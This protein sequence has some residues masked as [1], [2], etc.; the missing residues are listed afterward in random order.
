METTT[1]NYFHGSRE[2]TL[3]YWSSKWGNEWEPHQIIL[4]T[5]LVFVA[6][7]G[8]SSENFHPF[9][10]ISDTNNSYAYAIPWSG[11]W[12]V[13]IARI[14]GSVQ[15]SLESENPNLVGI[16]A[17]VVSGLWEDATNQLLKDFR[18]KHFATRKL[19]M[20]TE[21]NHWWPYEGTLINEDV[22]LRNAQV[23]QQCGIEVA[24]LDSGWFGSGA[25]ED[26]RGDWNQVNLTRFPSG[27]SGL[28]NK[29]RALGIEFGIWF[30]LES[31]GRESELQNKHPEYL[32]KRDGIPLETLC[33]ANPHA[34]R[35]ALGQL[36]QTI[37]DTKPSW[38][39]FDFNHSP[40]FGCNRVDHGHTATDGHLLHIENFY[41]LL[42]KVRAEYPEI[43]L[44]NCSSGGLRNDYGMAQ[45]VDFCFGSDRDWPEHALSVFW[46]H[47][48]FFPAETFL[49]WCDS[50]WLADQ[51]NQ[52]F[53]LDT[54]NVE[55][56]L[57][58]ILAVTLLGGFGLSQRLENFT[59]EQRNI[60][61]T[62]VELYR[63][64]LRPRYQNK[65][66]IKYLSDQPGRAQEGART[67][68]F[69]IETTMYPPLV[70]VFQLP[71]ASET[72]ITYAVN[73]DGVSYEAVDL[74]TG[75]HSEVISVDGNLVF[76]LPL[77]P[78][79]AY[80]YEIRLGS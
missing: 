34:F 63:P 44:E 21:W 24:V 74:I 35:W 68:G 61:R 51:P 39:K 9:F 69:A 53:K 62:Y 57:H 22:F 75:Q 60:L 73:T 45:R 50:E 58:F 18:E 64:S 3:R 70:M 16:G 59:P 40:G 23:A 52:N 27:L 76:D 46:A 12:S 65:A 17:H 25:W 79:T 55:G 47:S 29:T 42:E 20:K 4:G 7:T 71:G 36:L 31:V 15:I 28:A 30:E 43:T 11:N 19:A 33:F 14:G 2:V 37:Q 72:K 54:I 32:A 26:H 8:R 67:V 56:Q 78:N 48:H 49:G 66:S 6:D 38:I 41:L 1:L 10:V 13:Q 80:L 77:A 5:P